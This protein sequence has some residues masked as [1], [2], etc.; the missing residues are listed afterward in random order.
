MDK[1]PVDS[2]HKRVSLFETHADILTKRNEVT[3]G[4]KVCLSFGKTGV[5]LGAQVLRGNPAD[6]SLAVPAIELVQQNTGNTPH[7]AAMDRGFSS[8]ANVAALKEKGVQRVAFSK[9]KGIDEEKACG[10]RRICRK[11]YRFRAGVEGLI[12]WLKRSLAMGQSRWKG[13]Q[14]FLAYVCGV[15]MTASIQALARAD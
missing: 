9:G 6:S 8:I 10:N 14:G 4:H 2:T 3:Y 7:D 1:Q 12:S 13:E 15:V 5:V 11:L